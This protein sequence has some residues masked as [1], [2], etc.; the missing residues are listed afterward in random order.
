MTRKVKDEAIN[1][2]ECGTALSLVSLQHYNCGSM[3]GFLDEIL[4]QPEILE[5]LMSVEVEG[6][7]ET[8][9]ESDEIMSKRLSKCME[10]FLEECQRP[11]RYQHKI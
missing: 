8:V 6:E 1:M 7:L 4:N 11:W 10:S 5:R 3:A 9:T 2:E